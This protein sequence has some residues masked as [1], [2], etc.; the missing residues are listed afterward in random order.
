MSG[1]ANGPDAEEHNK[2]QRQQ[3]WRSEALR[4][5][6]RARGA[7]KKSFYGEK[8][9]QMGFDAEALLR[10]RITPEEY[11]NFEDDLDFLSASKES[12]DDVVQ[13][14]LA[15]FGWVHLGYGGF[16]GKLR[17]LQSQ[18]G[19]SVVFQARRKKVADA[20]F[21]IFKE[22]E[23]DDGRP[24]FVPIPGDDER[25]RDSFVEHTINLATYAFIGYGRG[26]RGSRNR[27]NDDIDYADEDVSKYHVSDYGDGEFGF[28]TVITTPMDA[29]ALGLPWPKR[30][31]DKPIR[32][33]YAHAFSDD[34]TGNRS[35]T[36][37]AARLARL[38][39]IDSV[40]FQSRPE[41]VWLHYKF[42]KQQGGARFVDDDM[43]MIY[44]KDFELDF[45]E[46]IP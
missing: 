20:H 22:W 44:A 26:R 12:R 43:N 30:E 8:R 11:E 17:T 1:N 14:I 21:Q 27:S 7:I 13:P 39:D 41:R 4:K 19:A 38:L 15:S 5:L 25:F 29:D 18:L 10:A 34:S 36:V 45:D 37:E 3:A 35:W 31:S 42:G 32:F 33:L 24:I 28:A 2:V 9:I 16:A 40:V 6:L 23:G 46:P